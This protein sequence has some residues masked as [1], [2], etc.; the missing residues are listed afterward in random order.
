M[1]LRPLAG[2]LVLVAALA[3]PAVAGA[4]TTA[5]G[6]TRLTLDGPAARTLEQRGVRVAAVAP[7]KKRSGQFVLPIAGG[8]VSSARVA[9]V[10]LRGGLRLTRGGRQVVLRSLVLKVGRSSKV[11][12]RVGGRSRTLFTVRSPKGAVTLNRAG[13]SVAVQNV[14]LRLTAGGAKLLSPR[15][16]LTGK[17]RLS[18]GTLATLLTDARVAAPVAAPAPTTPATPAPSTAVPIV[19]ASIVWRQRPSW[20]QYMETGKAYNGQPDPLGGTSALDGAVPGPVEEQRTSNGSVVAIPYTYAFPFASGWY[21][22]ATGR[23]Q[24]QF[25]GGLRH[26]YMDHGIDLTV[27]NPLV[28]LNGAASRIVATVGNAATSAPAAST[29]Y[30]SLD[31]TKAAASLDGNVITITGIPGTFPSDVSGTFSGFYAA[32]EPFGSVD[33]LRLTLGG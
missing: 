19:A 11:T 12:A 10:R 30:V 9:T 27:R 6:S 16:G 17:Q 25:A 22:T 29:N 14:A 4:K 32:G 23:A 31:A 21:D 18:A 8:K 24:I 15:L 5:S 7:A 20:L 3:A 1:S 13:Q 26:R 33:A 28:E 2:S